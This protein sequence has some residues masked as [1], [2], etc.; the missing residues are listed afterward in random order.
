MPTET[1]TAMMTEAP[2]VGPTFPPAPGNALCGCTDIPT[3]VVE[4]VS[5]VTNRTWMDRNLGASRR[6]TSQDDYFAYGCLFQWGRGLDGSASLNWTSSTTGMGMTG[7]VEGPVSK[8]FPACTDGEKFVTVANNQ[9]PFDDFDWLDPQN[10]TLWGTGSLRDPCPTGYRVPSEEEWRQELEG[11]PDGNE[12]YAKLG[13]TFAGYRSY[14][15][16]GG[17]SIGEFGFYW[18]R[19]SFDR[20]AVMYIS[21][22]GSTVGIAERAFGFSVRC[23]KA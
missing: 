1:P 22:G 16:G 5:P 9:A 21:P 11:I 7:T 23:I 12:A 15:T 8:P 4:L 6:A 3:K 20:D 14:P 13:L 18:S 10:N 17:V 19:T 2:T